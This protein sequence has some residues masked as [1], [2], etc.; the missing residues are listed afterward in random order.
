MVPRPLH[1]L[2]LAHHR[3]D[4]AHRC[5]QLPLQG[6]RLALCARCLGL[7]PAMAVTLALQAALGIGRAPLWDWWL[8]LGGTAPGLLDWGAGIIDPASGSNLRRL[9]SGI[10]LGAALG[11]SLWLYFADPHQEVFWVQVMLII[12]TAFASFAIKRI[13]PEEGI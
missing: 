9:F 7:Y 8:V 13:R 10:L 12:F 2:L 5:V 6:R 3:R 11:R 4:Q 1:L